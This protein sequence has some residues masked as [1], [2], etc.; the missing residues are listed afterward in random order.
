MKNIKL[1][2]FDMAGTTVD[3]DNVVYKTVTKVIN[4][5]GYD[6]TLAQVLAHGA[7]KEKH[8]AITDVLTNET[9]CANVA[10]VADRAFAEFKPTLAA[11]YDEL[12][13]KPISGVP[14]LFTFLK[15]NGISVVLNTG[16]D[17]KTANNLLTK[18]DWQVGRDIDGLITASDVINGRPAPDMIQAAMAIAG[19]TDTALVLK[20]G[21]S[22]IDVEEGV[23]AKCGASIGVLSGAQNREQLDSVN[24]TAIL[25]SLAELP[26]WLQA[27]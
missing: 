1:C 5:Q 6:V 9:D 7:G 12:D 10:E 18:L 20:A 19:V 26:A 13:V 3:E 11:A 24:P 8:Q 25:N 2:V 22:T 21:D 15:S 14:E 4:N 27:S 17:S 16:Y 23:N